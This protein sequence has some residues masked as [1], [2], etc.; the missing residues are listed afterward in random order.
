MELAQLG[1][2]PAETPFSWPQPRAGGPGTQ[3]IVRGSGRGQPCLILAFKASGSL[4]RGS[5]SSSPL[6]PWL[7]A[8]PHICCFPHSSLEAVPRRPQ[9]HTSC[10]L[11]CLCLL[12]GSFVLS[13]LPQLGGFLGARG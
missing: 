7:W 6:G 12:N 8:L 9:D 3:A 13:S 11:I 5:P 10:L 2:K 4:S 1:V